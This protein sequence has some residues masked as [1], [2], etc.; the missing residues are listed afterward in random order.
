ME[1]PKILVVGSMNMDLF[2]EGANTI[3]KFG[4]SIL[5]GNYGYA[6]GGKGSNQ[7]IAAALQ[8]ADVTMVGR[9]GDDTN[10]ESLRKE[11]KKAGVHTEYIVTDPDRQTGLALMLLHEDGR[12]VSYVAL[13]A[14]GGICGADVKAALDA[15]QFD[16]VIMQLEMP[17]ET[18]YQ[19]YEL[20]KERKI[21]VFLDAGPAMNIPLK[22]LEGLFILSPNEAETEA[23]T[24]INPD[25]EEKAIQ[26]AKMLYEEA[27]PEYVILKLGSRGAMLYD[28]NNTELIPC[29]KVKAVDSTAAGDTFGAAL[30]IRLCK[31]DDMRDAIRF[32]H[33]A[34]GICVSRMGAQVSI[35]REE[36]V[37]EFLSQ[38]I[39]VNS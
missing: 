30:A 13:G 7:A 29:F 12:Y 32:A 19:T 4:E 20:A 6:T 21:P 25:T 39:Q 37:A 16:M 5:C 9:L 14:N 10:G 36:E 1:K 2:V 26:A 8:G 27:K 35:P 15:C 33:A 11:L 28:G 17:L 24:G 38:S 18:V 22:R 3:P 34:A 31:G 23:L